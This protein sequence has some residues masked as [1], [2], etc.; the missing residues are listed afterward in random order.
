MYY[1]GI[2]I[3]KAFSVCS[4]I[5]Y[6][7]E[8]IIKP[9]S[10]KNLYNE[11]VAILY[12]FAFSNLLVQGLSHTKTKVVSFVTWFENSQPF[13]SINFSILSLHTQFIDQLTTNF[14]QPNLPV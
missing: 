1:V 6:K 14:A 7:E 11:Y 13:S 3:A 8:M 9:F 5:D 4:V 2:D 10:F 12:S